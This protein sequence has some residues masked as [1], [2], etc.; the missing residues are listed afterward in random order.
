MT[1]TQ[2]NAREKALRI[3]L[4]SVAAVF[5]VGTIT[6]FAAGFNPFTE[7][8]MLVTIFTGD[9]MIEVETS[10]TVVAEILEE[11][12]VA[13]D[14][15]FQRTIPELD[16]ELDVNYIVIKEA[17]KVAIRVDGEEWEVYSWAESIEELLI[18]Q[19]IDFDGD[20]VNL[21]LGQNLMTGLEIEITRVETELIEKEFALAADTTYRNDSSLNAG[22]QRV[23]TEARD[24][25]KVVTYEV[26]YHDGEEVSREIV[27]EKVVQEPVTGVVLRGT[28]TVASRSNPGSK[29]FVQEGIASYYGDK[30]HGNKTYFG[31]T[32]DMYA[33]TAA[34]LTLPHNTMVKVTNLNNNKSVVVRINDRGPHI[35]GRIIDLSKAA[36]RE[37]GVYPGLANV[38]IEVVQ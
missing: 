29:P 5:L 14:P 28:R 24:G 19:E 34:H 23:Q 7:S 20:L 21:P 17:P 37:I 8:T 36:A 6:L 27:A 26:T 15:E 2:R 11:A 12:E 3:S 13:I 1:G 32:Y 18:E 35:D 30:F 9:D 4:L 10:N 25:K 16:A 31:E 22:V 38:R 33:M